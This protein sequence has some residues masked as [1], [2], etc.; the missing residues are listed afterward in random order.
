M[1]AISI[2]TG[3]NGGVWTLTAAVGVD[4]EDIASVTV[5]TQPYVYVVDSGDNA[6]SRTSFNVF[7]VKEPVITGG[8]GS[9]ASGT[10]YDTIVCT[11]PAANLPSNKDMECA[12]ADQSNGDLYFIT[13]RISPILLYK[14]PYAA[15]YSGTQQLTY[16][17]TTYAM[18][19]ST[20]ASG[21]NNGYVTGCDM[22]PNNL[23][24]VV[25]NYNDM[26]LFQR[27]STNTTILQMLQQTPTYVSGY[28]GAN[29]PSSHPNNEPQ[30]EAVAWGQDGVD[31]YTASEYVSGVGGT[32]DTDYP[33]FKYSRLS[34]TY[35]EVSFQDG[36]GIS[37]GNVDT[38]LYSL[39]ASSAVNRGGETTFVADWN[40]DAPTDIRQGLLKFNITGISSTNT[41]VGVDLFLTITTEGSTF[42]VYQMYD[43]W[44]ESE[45]Y[46]SRGGL[47]PA[48]DGVH[49]SSS[50]LAYAGNYATLT[51][52]IQVNIPNTV[53]QEWV[54]GT[55]TNQ[56]FLIYSN[57]IPGG[58]GFQWGSRD[59][60]TLANRPKL[61]VRYY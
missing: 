13:K 47:F 53:V 15:S 50:T 57:D 45:T 20:Q 21:S 35:T 14:L 26:Y 3:G 39:L 40:A 9:L 54:N 1:R 60:A 16:G 31:L 23:E 17:G 38:Y 2:S 42:Q 11:F 24:L 33:F 61:T 56:G 29:R 28:V 44:V 4:V 10:N 55:R 30:G 37:T 43:S 34:S 41:I 19:F 36:L 25:K 46:A 6:S 59:N 12:F 27:T 49:A 18:A 7:R 22:S 32:T 5:G 51:G 48:R 58:N 8:A 52:K